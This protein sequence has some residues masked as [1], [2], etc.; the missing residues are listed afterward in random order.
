VVLYVCRRKWFGLQ[1]PRRTPFLGRLAR[2]AH[3]CARAAEALDAAGYS[4]EL[5]RVGGY[6]A[7][8]WTWRSRNADRAEVRRLSGT[9]EVPILVL[10]DGEVVSGSSAIARWAK[11]P[12]RRRA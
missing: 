1:P 11:T 12:E 10:D 7:S 6:R 9:N 3:P 4:Y 2:T 5:K 8:P